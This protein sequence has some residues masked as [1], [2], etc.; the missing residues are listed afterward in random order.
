[1]FGASEKIVGENYL[2]RDPQNVV[3]HNN[4]SIN[5]LFTKK[6][7]KRILLEGIFKEFILTRYHPKKKDLYILR[8]RSLYIGET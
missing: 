1:M 3:H 5:F 7:Y 4:V 6:I 2:R 8:F